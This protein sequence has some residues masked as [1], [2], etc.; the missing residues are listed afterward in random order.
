MKSSFVNYLFIALIGFSSRLINAVAFVDINRPPIG[1]KY[2]KA[3]GLPV[4]GKQVFSLHILS[5]DTAHLLV[6]GMLFL[7][8]IIAYTVASGG[9]LHCRLSDEALKRLKLFR[10][11]LK[12]VGYDGDTDTPYVKVTTP[13]PMPVKIHLKRKESYIGSETR[14]SANLDESDEGDL[15]KPA[16]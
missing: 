2:E 9:C 12:E 8:E 3:I 16:Q 5:D 4:L 13:L 14:I 7:D 15:I 10:T 1:A 6:K 11:T